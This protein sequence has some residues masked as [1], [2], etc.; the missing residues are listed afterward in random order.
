MSLRRGELMR[1]AVTQ[2]AQVERYLPKQRDNVSSNNLQVLRVI[3]Y[4][5]EHNCNIVLSA[6]RLCL[7]AQVLYMHELMA[8][9]GLLRSSLKLTPPSIGRED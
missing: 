1:I 2:F 7:L 9:L 8:K 5:A 4:L 6:Q 3:R